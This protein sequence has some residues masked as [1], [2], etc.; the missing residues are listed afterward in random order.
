MVAAIIGNMFGFWFGKKAGETLYKRKESFLFRKRHVEI[1]KA[2]Y[3]KH[4]GK[5]LIIGRFLP[6]I[7]T[8]AP[9]LAGVI[10]IDFEK[11]MM[12][13]VI[14]AVL[15]IGSIGSIAFYLGKQFPQ[16]ENYLGYIF[17]TLIALTAIPI[18]TTYLKNRKA[19][20]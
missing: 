9:I 4:G 5:T 18:L 7:R 3:E 19:K 17:I 16:V 1:T 15:W 8:F 10:K 14:G 20:V 12:Y 6:I 2:Y 11:F 13:N